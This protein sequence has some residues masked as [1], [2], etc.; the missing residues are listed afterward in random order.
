[1]LN[2]HQLMY[3]EMEIRKGRI[4]TAVRDYVEEEAEKAALL[5]RN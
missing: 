1:M 5:A 2:Q 3:Y 4:A